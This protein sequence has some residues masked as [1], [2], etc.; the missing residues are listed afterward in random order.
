LP[1]ARVLLSESRQ[2]APSVYAPIVS[3]PKTNI[4]FLHF[5]D[6]AMTDL[7][8]VRDK[9]KKAG[10]KVTVARVGPLR[11]ALMASY[12]HPVVALAGGPTLLIHG[13]DLS[14]VVD[15]SLEITSLPGHKA[16]LL[17]ALL[18][19]RVFYADEV[20]EIKELLKKNKKGEL[21]KNPFAE[22]CGVLNA[23][24]VGLVQAIDQAAY[25]V[26]ATL[27]LH[28][29]VLATKQAAPPAADK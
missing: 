25:S 11:Q 5:N 15:A 27:D 3:D 23:P 19:R 28:A 1:K 12:A 24:Q 20:R 14:S 16:I 2:K 17:G 8:K 4:S 6:L 29:H 13:H 22:I 7:T 21:V 26:P 18:N 10:V 9:Y